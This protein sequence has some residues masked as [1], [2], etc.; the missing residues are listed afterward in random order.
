M[1]RNDRSRYNPHLTA[2]SQVV[3]CNATRVDN[4]VKP[5]PFVSSSLDR[6]AGCRGLAA[7]SQCQ[8]VAHTCPSFANQTRASVKASRRTYARLS[9]PPIVV[10]AGRSKSSPTIASRPSRS[11]TR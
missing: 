11:A 3:G 10:V 4:Y 6:D 9:T 7:T 1:S 2:S 5:S 8:S